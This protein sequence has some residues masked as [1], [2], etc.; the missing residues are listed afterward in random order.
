M[1][2]NAVPVFLQLGPDELCCLHK[3]P[4]KN[5]AFRQKYRK[6]LDKRLSRV[7]S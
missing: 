1:A 5:H 4:C 6:P 7:Y 2:Q 3:N